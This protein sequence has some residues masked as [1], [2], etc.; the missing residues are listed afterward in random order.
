MNTTQIPA[1]FRPSPTAVRIL[2]MDTGDAVKA[3]SGNNVMGA[4]VAEMGAHFERRAVAAQKAAATRARN[5]EAKE[6][7]DHARA[8]ATR[9]GY[10]FQ[11]PAASGA[12]WC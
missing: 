2:S 8:V 9:C 10:C 7:R 11:I 3:M 4:I 6:K 12:C 5:A 1:A